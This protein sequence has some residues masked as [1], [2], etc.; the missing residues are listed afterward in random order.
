MW[1]DSV[2]SD[3]VNALSWF[4]EGVQYHH[5]ELIAVIYSDAFWNFLNEFAVSQ[6]Q[7][8]SFF[9]GYSSPTL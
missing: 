2:L 1:L 9:L 6:C 7:R 8:Q 4:D 5:G 3:H